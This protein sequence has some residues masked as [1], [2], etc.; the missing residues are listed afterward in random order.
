M[1]VRPLRDRTASA[2]GSDIA[3]LPSWVRMGG[4]GRED[5]RG[6]AG[7]PRHREIKNHPERRV[8]H[9]KQRI[10]RNNGIAGTTESQRGN[11]ERVEASAR[12]AAAIEQLATAP[13]LH[14]CTKPEF[15]PTL[16]VADLAVVMHRIVPR[17]GLKTP[18]S[19]SDRP[20]TGLNRPRRGLARGFVRAQPASGPLENRGEQ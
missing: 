13:G 14:P 7:V 4:D 1:V 6:R 12:T 18:E 15:A 10:R 2:V 3:R 5:G 11:S 9:Q 17:K 16:D 20:R 8:A 19:A